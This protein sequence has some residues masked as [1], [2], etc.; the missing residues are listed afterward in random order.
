MDKIDFTFLS[1]NF[2]NKHKGTQST[3]PHSIK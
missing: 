1:V 2:V 3:I